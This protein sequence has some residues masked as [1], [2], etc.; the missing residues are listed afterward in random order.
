MTTIAP[1]VNETPL[2]F[3]KTAPAG[4]AAHASLTRN[5]RAVCNVRQTAASV[6]VAQEDIAQGRIQL[7]INCQRFVRK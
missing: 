2:W 4:Q 5:G 1:P 3:W 7:C 6:P